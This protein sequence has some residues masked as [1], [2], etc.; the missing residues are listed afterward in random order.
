[1]GNAPPGGVLQKYRGG[2]LLC[3]DENQ[4]VKCINRQAVTSRDS[5]LSERLEER[6]QAAAR[7]DELIRELFRL[8]DLNKNDLLEEQ[9]LIK[10]NQKIAMLHYGKGSK[11]ADHAKVE[12]KYRNHFREHLDAEGKPV[13]FAKFQ[14]YMEGMLNGIDP[15]PRAQ[16]MMLEQWIAE[17]ES[18]RA[19]FFCNSMSSVSDFEYK[20]NISFRE[21]MIY[22]PKDSLPPTALPGAGGSWTGQSFG[23]ERLPPEAGSME[24]SSPSNSRPV[25]TSGGLPPTSGISGF[26]ASEEFVPH[27]GAARSGYT[28][29]ESFVPS[30]S[31]MGSTTASGTMGSHRPAPQQHLGNLGTL[32][33]EQAAPVSQVSHG[34]ALPATGTLGFVEAPVS[35]FAKGQTLEVWSESKKVW[36]PGMVLAAYETATSTEGYDVPAG[37]VKVSS[38][39]GVKW[40]LP[41][42]IQ[43]MLRQTGLTYRKGDALQVWSE[44]QNVW[45][46]AIVEE[47]YAVDTKGRGFTIP[48]GSLL[49]K[50]IAGT[51]K[52]IMPDQISQMLRPSEAP[53]MT[54]FE[55]GEKIQVWSESRKDWLLGVVQEIFLI[56][57]KTEGFDVPAGSLKVLSQ[58]GV[59]W[60][61]PGDRQRMVRKVTA[62]SEVD[63]K[64]ML[65]AALSEPSTLHRQAESVWSS[66]LL[67]GQQVLPAEHAAYALEGLAEQ[68]GLKLELEGQHLEAVKRRAYSFAGGQDGLNLD[69]F[70]QLCRE[71]MSELYG[72]LA[73]GM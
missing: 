3:L 27:P 6:K 45:M 37:T 14:T 72:K 70:E 69:Q 52:W 32:P 18:G 17:A 24:I 9:E 51:S 7:L 63:L 30:P 21:S 8:Q 2:W 60:I 28:S 46:D 22:G 10:L 66:A 71:M 26:G 65:K 34:Q 29:T 25:P 42:Q 48:A 57:T 12:E 62:P 33:E 38:A 39:N 58:T 13:N 11:D 67:P 47:A 61:L 4:R 19:A 35:S 53:S 23:L 15:D 16:E 20:Q 36:L 40:V 43:S 73:G 50:S 64:S 1:M 59:K 55:R 49:V 41:N 54:S 44:S 68:F 56:D 31:R 5:G